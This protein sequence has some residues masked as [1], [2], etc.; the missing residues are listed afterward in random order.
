[1]VEDSCDAVDINLGC[2]QGI[3]RKG[4]YGAFLL[5][6]YELLKNIVSTMHKGLKIPVTC[7]IRLFDDI[8]ESIKLAIMLQDAGCALLTVHG[9]TKEEK[10]DR[11]GEVNFDGIKRIKAALRIPVIANGG[12]SSKEDA[13]L[14]MKYTGCDGV[15]SSEAILENPALFAPDAVSPV[16]ERILTNYEVIDEYLSLARMHANLESVTKKGQPHI[17][18]MVRAHLF[19]MLHHGFQTTTDIRR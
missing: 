7:K 4:H 2:P 12:V 15:M 5:T 11:T 16:G 8:E 10:K 19:K 14:I 13:D 3:A 9:R 17:L 18:K 1:M 6:E